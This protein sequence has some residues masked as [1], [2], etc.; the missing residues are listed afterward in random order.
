MLQKGVIIRSIVG[1]LKMSTLTNGVQIWNVIRMQDLF[2]Q[3]SE[4][5]GLKYRSLAKMVEL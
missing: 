1:F 3:M 2:T 4:V 5:N